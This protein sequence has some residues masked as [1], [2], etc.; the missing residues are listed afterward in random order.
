MSSLAVATV[1]RQGAR[2]VVVANRTP[3]PGR[4]PGRDDTERARSA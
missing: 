1:V 3:A 2:Q 4:A